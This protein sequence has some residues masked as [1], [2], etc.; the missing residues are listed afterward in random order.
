MTTTTPARE[1][2]GWI[3]AWILYGLGHIFSRPLSWWAWADFAA[4]VLYPAYNRCML[5]SLDVQQWAGSKG[6]WRNS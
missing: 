2:I 5:A 1:V 6:P 4:P 3:A